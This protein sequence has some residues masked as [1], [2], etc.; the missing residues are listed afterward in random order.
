METGNAMYID[1]KVTTG[2][3]KWAG[4]DDKIYVRLLGTH[5]GTE[6]IWLDKAGDDFKRNDDSSFTFTV[7]KTEKLETDPGPILGVIIGIEPK[8][9]MS[10]PRNKKVDAI[11]LT[12]V[13]VKR[14]AIYNDDGSQFSDDVTY[15]FP[16]PNLILG[17]KGDG[18]KYDKRDSDKHAAISYLNSGSNPKPDTREVR[19]PWKTKWL[20]L[21][22]S[23]A[24]TQKYKETLSIE[25]TT[26]TFE[27]VVK[28]RS[29]TQT[30]SM[31]AAAEATILGIGASLSVTGEFSSTQ[32]IL[33]GNS[34]EEISTKKTEKDIDLSVPANQ[35]L[36]VGFATFIDTV[37][38]QFDFET[39]TLESYNPL[40]LDITGE[41][42]TWEEADTI[43]DLPETYR[44]I[45]QG[46]VPVVLSGS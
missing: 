20:L 9:K 34:Y 41:F 27:E 14:R 4:T 23:T 8:F 3:A 5:Y 45:A 46:L 36:L 21:R 1:I 13:S 32:E 44:E 22:N 42:V 24:R 25:Y 17:D 35:V 7:G 37:R 31:T 16:F 12:K 30:I 19:I 38:R 33:E 18:D 2:T 26:T 11:Q 28:S 29:D 6:K 10:D 39:L 15:D 43:D 40:S